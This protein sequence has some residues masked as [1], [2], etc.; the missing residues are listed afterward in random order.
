MRVRI[1]GSMRHV[2]LAADDGFAVGGVL[3]SS[4]PMA[5]SSSWEDWIQV[6]RLHMAI[7]FVSSPSRPAGTSAPMQHIGQTPRSNNTPLVGR[8]SLECLTADCCGN[9]VTIMLLS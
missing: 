9:G 5:L 7:N 6:D 4:H 1:H 3:R 2:S 8:T